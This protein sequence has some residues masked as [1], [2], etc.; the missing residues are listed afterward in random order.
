MVT[1]HS[2]S[3]DRVAI[4][5][6]IAWTLAAFCPIVFVTGWTGS[7]ADTLFDPRGYHR[8]ATIVLWILALSPVAGWWLLLTGRMKNF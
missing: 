7:L 1:Q 3:S 5:V 8:I 6:V 4:A 2:R